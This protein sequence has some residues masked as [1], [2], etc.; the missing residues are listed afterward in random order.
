[1]LQIGG[2]VVRQQDCPAQQHEAGRE[3]LTA[4]DDA[5]H[6]FGV[7]WMDGEEQC[8]DGCDGVVAE[9]SP[10]EGPDQ[11]ADA[12]VQQH[13][14]R[15]VAEGPQLVDGVVEREAEEGQWAVEAVA[16]RV[17]EGL[18]LGGAVPPVR[19]PDFAQVG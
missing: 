6:G 11:H 8:G 9:Q 16:G 10:A 15:V 4:S 18:L 7:D 3:N 12:G 2:F 14:E 17:G 13:I 19:Q 1:M 5:G